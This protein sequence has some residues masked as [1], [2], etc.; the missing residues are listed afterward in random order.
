MAS[1]YTPSQIALYEA[2]IS[3]P[4]KYRSIANPPPVKNLDYLTALYVHQISSVPYENLLLHY[5]QSHA[6]SLDPQ[7]LFKK[8]VTDKRGRGGVHIV[9]IVTL[10]TGEKYALDVGFGGDQATKP[11]P[12]TS[13]HVV[14]NLGAQE[15]RLIHSTIPEQAD[16]TKKLWIY[17]YRNGADKEWNSFYSFPEVEFLASDFEIINFFTSNKQGGTNFQTRTVLT[18]RFL[19]G[20]VEGEE[21][22]RIVGKVMLV[23]G[24]VK[25]NDGGKTRVIAVCETE[26]ER[27]KALKEHFEIELTEEE[28]AG[29]KGRN[30]ELIGA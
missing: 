10:P 16:Q 24:E 7:V 14:Q 28:V 15:I 18:V 8:I 11:L 26:E 5:S 3:L 22:E 9:N 6:V 25:R 13:G 20:K 4:A 23:N 2:H 12:M 29:V 21:D 19:R 1:A 27:I 17:Q 30:V